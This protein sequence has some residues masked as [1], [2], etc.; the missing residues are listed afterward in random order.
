[1][2]SRNSVNLITE[3]ERRYLECNICTELFDEDER[4]PRLLPCH[5][6]FCSECI[7]RLGHRKDTFKCPTCNTVHKVKRNG[8]LDFPK[9]NT[10][11][12]LTSFLQAHSELNALKKCCLC[13]N[14]VDATYT[15]QQCYINL[16]EICRHLHES[17]NKTHTSIIN[18]SETLQEEDID[19]CQNP[20]HERAKLKHFC[21]SS[22]CQT[23]LCPS[24]VIAEHRDP[25]K[26]ELEDIEEAFMK[27]KKNWEMT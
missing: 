5:H 16:C 4:I 9:D 3:L 10:R 15:C 1:M 6:P 7:K 25:S 8:P 17:E 18:K 21:N 20:N 14:T 19:V 27:R 24:C 13:G 23:V 26:H 2:A 11:R 22:N 12:D